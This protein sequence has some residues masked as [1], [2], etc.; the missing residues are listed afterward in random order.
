[1]GC[2]RRPAH[3]PAS[4]LVVPFEPGFI[5]VGDKSRRWWGKGMSDVMPHIGIDENTADVVGC[6][7][8]MTVWDRLHHD[9]TLWIPR[10]QLNL[11]LGRVNTIRTNHNSGL[12]FAGWA[13]S[14]ILTTR[15]RL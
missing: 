3:P 1:M 11:V 4:D 5:V 14:E 15:F 13:C 7:R 9:L 6:P 2:V 12:W 8:E 10:P